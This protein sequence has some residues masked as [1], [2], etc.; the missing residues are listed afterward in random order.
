MKFVLTT[1][2]TIQL[3][4]A[5]WLCRVAETTATKPAPQW[6]QQQPQQGRHHRRLLWGNQ[7]LYENDFNV[8]EYMGDE[9]TDF[10]QSRVARVVQFYS[11][12]CVSRIIIVMIIIID[13]RH[14]P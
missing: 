14:E 2:T 7:F 10:K 4:L 6:K 3:Y 8:V 13:R 9:N 11:P 1:I 12:Y 5:F